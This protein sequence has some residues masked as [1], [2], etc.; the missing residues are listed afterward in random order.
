MLLT[1]RG[2]AARTAAALAG[3]IWGVRATC[4]AQ[5]GKAG[6]VRFAV[7]LPHAGTPIRARA[8]LLQRLGYQGLEFS[9]AERSWELSPRFILGELKGIEIQVSA[10]GGACEFQNPDPRARAQGI[11]QD[12]KCLELARA[13]GAKQM[14]EHY[15]PGG[16]TLQEEDQLVIEA[17]KQ[18][19]ADVQRTGVEIVLEPLSH[20]DTHHTDLQEHAVRVVQAVGAPGIKVVSD[21]NH[22]QIENN[23][24]EAALTRWGAYTGAVHLPGEK[25]FGPGAMP[26]DYRPGFRALKRHGYSG[27]LS[28]ESCFSEDD[29]GPCLAGALEYVK[30]QWSEA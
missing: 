10:V 5:I 30:E 4:G 19:A 26:L 28:I 7:M 20:K 11:E 25:R 1:R 24:I 14:G 9:G 15:L 6:D 13:L 2:F 23:D 3:T 17:L 18:L 16:D 8:L 12:R 21:F 22:M 29:P 27:W